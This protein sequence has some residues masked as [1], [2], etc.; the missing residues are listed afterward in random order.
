MSEP[1]NLTANLT[2][3]VAIVTGASQGLGQ[4]MALELAIN[5]A[6]V[7]CIARNADKLAQTVK[8]ITDAGGQAEA[9]PGDV[10]DGAA[11]TALVDKIATDWGRLDILVK[12]PASRAIRS[13]R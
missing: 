11:V 10:K 3:Q 1:R 6:K 2:G 12:T 5:G 9:F 4:A 13:C 7:A 8:M